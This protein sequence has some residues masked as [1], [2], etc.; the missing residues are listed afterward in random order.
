[1]NTDVHNSD[2][3]VAKERT[4]VRL[5]FGQFTLNNGD[6]IRLFGTPGLHRF[7]LLWKILSKGALGLII[8]ADNSRPDPLADMSVY[9]NRF[10]EQLDTLPCAIGV[11]RLDT[12]PH[13]SLD[14]FA[15]LLAEKNRIF[16]V[17]GVDVR[18]KDDVIL[19]ID[20]LLMQL[21]SGISGVQS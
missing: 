16:P 2:T 4:T 21:E 1:M 10:S 9:L 13:P 12:H 8:L 11:G 18:R 17:I 3:S 14:H 6:R 15:N 20:T 19:L 5:D 7:N